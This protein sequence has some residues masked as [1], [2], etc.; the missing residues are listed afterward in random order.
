MTADELRAFAHRDWAAVAAAKRS[1]WAEQFRAHGCRPAWEAS[2]ALRAAMAHSSP[3]YPSP[4][5]RAADHAHHARLAALLTRC[6]HAFPCR[7][8]TR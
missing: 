6:A 5:D 4:A 8:S 1:Y 3:G 7:P 2:N